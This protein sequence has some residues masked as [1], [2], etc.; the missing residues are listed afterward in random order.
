MSPIR[1]RVTVRRQRRIAA[2]MCAVL[3]LTGCT[4][5]RPEEPADRS[6]ELTAAVER[7]LDDHLGTG[8]R[9]LRS[10]LVT[11]D[12]ELVVE[13]YVGDGAQAGDVASVTKSVLST[14]VGIAV[15]EGDLGLDRT[16]ADAMPSYADRMSPETAAI[17]VE[18]LLTMTSGLRVDA[19]HSRPLPERDDWVALILRRGPVRTPGEEWGYSSETSHLLAAVLVEATGRP[20]L[21]YARQKLFEPLGIATQGAAEPVLSEGRAF[22][23]AYERADV[24]WPR[25][26]SGLHT[27]WGY[28]KLR[29]ADLLKLG[30]LY[31][32]EGRWQG[33]QL[34][35]AEWV[36]AATSPAAETGLDVG[37]H[38]GY[39]WWVGGAGGHASYAA[40]GYGGQ[41]VQV[42]PDV[43][44]VVVATMDIDEI[45]TFDSGTWQLMTEYVL[46][47][48]LEGEAS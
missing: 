19:A 29:P 13:H 21:D 32:D 26:P 39:Q 15:H 16:L 18:Q 5:Q 30:N 17:T 47:P 20:L 46:L 27:G 4:G 28:L 24:A 34:V 31:L 44:L 12:G 36:R 33:E 41:I 10:V 14:L 1:S 35:P 45:S 25:D 37:E 23:R 8:L 7:F 43:D 2:W 42:V 6:A 22:R 38:Y 40:I 3:V 48:V 11:V 9:H